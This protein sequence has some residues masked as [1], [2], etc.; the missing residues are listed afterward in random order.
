MKRTL[1]GV[2]AALVITATG[3]APV[4][5][6]TVTGPYGTLTA[7]DATASDSQ[8]VYAQQQLTLTGP[9]SGGS[10]DVTVTGPGGVAQYGSFDGGGAGTVL[11]CGSLDPAGTYAM[12]VAISDSDGNYLGALDTTFRFALL[13]TT[14]KTTK[15]PAIAKGK[16][17]W[18]VTGVLTTLGEP[19]KRRVVRV[20]ARIDGFWVTVPGEGVKK[21]TNSKGVVAYTFPP[22]RITWR[23]FVAPAKKKPGAES[24]PF[25]TPFR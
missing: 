23:Y 25:T 20:Q 12:H 9:A 24:K 4:E 18:E 14:V 3:A 6:G 22:S 10:S 11:L 19:E 2:A 21:R 16:R 17:G 7:Q 1:I 15:T 5:A 13:K 8:C